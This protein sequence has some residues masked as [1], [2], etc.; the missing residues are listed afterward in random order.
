MHGNVWTAKTVDF[1]VQ[2][3]ALK[4]FGKFGNASAPIA[5]DCG[6]WAQAVRHTDPY[7]FGRR[8]RVGG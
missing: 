3:R 4:L 2:T 7:A 5:V 6:Q 8:A 1:R